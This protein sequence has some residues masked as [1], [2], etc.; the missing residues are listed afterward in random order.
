MKLSSREVF[1]L[2]D[3]CFASAGL[4]KGASKANAKSI[5]WTEVYKERGL[6]ALHKII[7]ES[8]TLAPATLSLENQTSVF[9]ILD[10]SDQPSI[11]SSMAALDFSCSQ[12]KREGI[13]ITYSSIPESDS[14]FPTIGHTVYNAANRGMVSIVLTEYPDGS[15]SFI[16]MPSRP[17]PIVAETELE[18]PSSS[19]TKLLNIIDSGLYRQRHSPLVQAFFNSG[20]RRSRSATDAATLERLLDDATESNPGGVDSDE[21]GFFTICVDPNHP[22]NS[23]EIRRV[24]DQFV[25]ERVDALTT[26]HRPPKI[27]ERGKAL[28]EEGIDVE[29]RVWEELFEFS[30]GVFSPDSLGSETGAG[31]GLER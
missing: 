20:G 2:A 18:W 17:H 6:T 5:W 13:G 14:S 24:A 28:I 10:S 26:V 15:G 7:E 3:R 25:D 27:R 12:A 31:P 16:G 19:Y 30:N 8:P 11:V 1:Q 29:E 22:R 9:S 4:S 21:R 23:A